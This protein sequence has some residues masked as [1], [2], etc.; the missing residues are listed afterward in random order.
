M[1]V[2]L[3]CESV[4]EISSQFAIIIRTS[5]LIKVT[6]GII[7]VCRLHVC[8]G[9]LSREQVKTD[10]ASLGAQSTVMVERSAEVCT[11]QLRAAV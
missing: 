5:Q 2:N 3:V 6:Y 4:F 8:S 1:R 7:I 11:L 10:K 9:S